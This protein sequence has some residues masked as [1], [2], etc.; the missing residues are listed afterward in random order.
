MEDNFCGVWGNLREK[1]LKEK[2]PK[3]YEVLL[4]KGDLVEYLTSY[5]VSYS[6]R[7]ERIFK[8]LLS[9][10]GINEELYEKNSLE[11]I[12]ETEKIQEEVKELLQEE[13]QK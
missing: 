12:M 6:H 10:R 1:Y 2:K 5:Q 11:W 7:A 3:L 4:A 13:I 8:E 9:K